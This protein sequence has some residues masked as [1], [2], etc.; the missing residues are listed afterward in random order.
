MRRLTIGLVTPGFSADEDDWCIP[1]LRDLVRVL[2]RDHRVT[3]YTLRYPHQRQ[4]YGVFG[5]DVR[6]FGGAARG[7]V[8][9]LPLLGR[10]VMAIRRDS[11]RQPFSVL[12]GVWADEAGFTAAMAGR[13]TGTPVLVSLMGGELVSMPDIGYGVGLSRSGRLMTRLSLQLA[14]AVSAGSRHLQEMASA[15]AGCNMVRRLPLGTD[16]GL[17]RPGDGESQEDG[18]RVLHVGSLSAVK[19]HSTLLTA[20]AGAIAFLG[21]G[22]ITL[23]IAG[24]GPQMAA[25]KEEVQALGI[26]GLV[27][28]HGEVSHERLP[29]MYQAADLFVLS[30]RY[31]SQNLA[32]LEAAACGVPIVGTATGILPELLPP[33][34]LAPVGDAAA[35]SRIMARMLQDEAERAKEGQR[36]HRLASERYSLART[37]P[38]LLE[39]YMQLANGQRDSATPA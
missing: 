3:V 20:F 30:S 14:D 26:D 27:H 16:T 29:S 11:R 19:D 21:Q 9:R 28:F 6:A 35:L 36:L 34:Y 39:T 22:K 5:A 18:L 38:R 4:N 2:A 32:V 15:H 12:H 17:F 33:Q 8:R 31:E 7:G 23:H 1:A 37:V 10:A 24:G 13:L 25:L